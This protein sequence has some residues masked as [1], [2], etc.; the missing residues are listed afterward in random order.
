MADAAVDRADVERLM[1]AVAEGETAAK[2]KTKARAGAGSRQ[3]DNP[4]HDVVRLADGRRK[5]RL[6]DDE[7]A[8]LGTALRRP[9]AKATGRPPPGSVSRG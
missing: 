4:V 2:V 6:S 8:A 9:E 5:R 7:Y 1:H 3:P